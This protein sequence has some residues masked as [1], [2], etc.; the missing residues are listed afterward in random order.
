ML[1]KQCGQDISSGEYLVID[2]DP[3]CRTCIHDGAE[4]VSLYPIGVVKAGTG[5]SS[6]ESVIELQPF[7]KKFMFRLAEETHLTIVYHLHKVSGIR[8]EFHRRIDNK[9][10]GVFASRTP[11]RP[12]PIAVTEVELVRMDDLSLVVLGLDAMENSPVLDIKLGYRE[13]QRKR[14]RMCQDEQTK[15]RET[16]DP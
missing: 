2:G 7:M 8:T 6:D 11:C 14:P 1:C 12:T 5:E 15:T 10:V 3:T 9:K 4:P 13:I 16:T